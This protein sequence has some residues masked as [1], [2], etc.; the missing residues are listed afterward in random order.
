MPIVATVYPR[1]MPAR[2]SWAM[3]ASVMPPT[4]PWPPSKPSSRRLPKAGETLKTGASRKPQRPMPTTYCPHITI[5]ASASC[6]K[7]DDA[8]FLTLG[9]PLPR[10][11][12]AN[13]ILMRNPGIRR[14][15]SVISS[16]MTDLKHVTRTRPRSPPTTDDGKYSFWR[17]GI[18]TRSIL[19]ETSR[20]ESITNIMTAFIYYKAIQASTSALG[21]MRREGPRP[22]EP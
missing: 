19:P 9:T 12:V 6:G 21:R 8:R 4:V 7:T 13:M 22:R 3:N 10:K 16:G 2:Q 1:A 5:W 15:S 17:R 14:I 11:S 18:W 20:M